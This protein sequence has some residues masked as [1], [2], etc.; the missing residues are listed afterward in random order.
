MSDKEYKSDG[1]EILNM[2]RDQLVGEVL[3]RITALENLL[4][5]KSIITEIEVQE[6]LKGLSLKIA[7]IIG[8]SLPQQLP[9][10][11][12]EKTQERPQETELTNLYKQFML[13]TNKVSKGN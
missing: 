8:M 6:E 7:N 13:T 2:Q 4:I 5:K 12:E 10:I 1:Y 3:L 11:E 9:A